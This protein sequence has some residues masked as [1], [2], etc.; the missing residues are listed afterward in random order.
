MRMIPDAG[1]LAHF[2][3]YELGERAVKLNEKGFSGVGGR[4]F[5]LYLRS[6]QLPE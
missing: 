1:E 2:C 4:A 5:D 6:R 3:C